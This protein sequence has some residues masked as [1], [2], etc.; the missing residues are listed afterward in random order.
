MRRD[1]YPLENDEAKATRAE[2]QISR[3]LPVRGAP[4][5][6]PVQG[7]RRGPGAPE[8]PSG[9]GTSPGAPPATRGHLGHRVALISARQIAS[10]RVGADAVIIDR[11]LCCAERSEEGRGV[12]NQIALHMPSCSLTSHVQPV[13]REISCTRAVAVQ[14]SVEKGGTARPRAFKNTRR[15]ISRSSSE[16]D[17]GKREAFLGATD[18]GAT[19]SR[20]EPSARER[21]GRD[22]GPPGVPGLGRQ[23]ATSVPCDSSSAA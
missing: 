11:I 2:K 16:P 9:G 5:L 8:R 10:A 17:S 22:I 20:M 3:R 18:R 19:R 23:S 14:S 21:K 4:R 13:W 1:Q 7:A 12:S 15:S 6:E